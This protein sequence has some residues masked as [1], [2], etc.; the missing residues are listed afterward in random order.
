MGSIILFSMNASLSPFSRLCP[1]T[2][3]QRV[4]APSISRSPMSL[5][6]W[7]P[8]APIFFIEIKPPTHLPSISTRKDA[9]NQVRT[10]FV[11]RPSTEVSAIGRQLSY[12]TYERA[13]GAVEP[14]V[15]A[16]SISFVVDT[17]LIERWNT[18]ILEEGSAKFL[19][20]VQEIKQMVAILGTGLC[21]LLFNFPHVILE[22]LWYILSLWA[23]LWHR[24]H[25]ISLMARE[26]RYISR[27]LGMNL[28]DY[29]DVK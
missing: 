27:E 29:S 17:A 13:T 7:I 6:R 15:L 8:T 5:S 2:S 10:R 24:R 26:R 3:L 11:Q 18:N 12:Y 16:D 9:E 1:S 28:C 4:P 21:I 20:V 19:A 25:S 23:S 22:A 14:I